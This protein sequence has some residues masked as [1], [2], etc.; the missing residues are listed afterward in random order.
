VAG[1]DE[2]K[3]GWGSSPLNLDSGWNWQAEQTSWSSPGEFRVP[4]FK[5]VI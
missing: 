4:S 2:R 3:T 1:G 5:F